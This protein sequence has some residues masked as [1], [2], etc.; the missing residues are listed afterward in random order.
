MGTTREP[1]FYESIEEMNK[2]GSELIDDL[3]KE[4]SRIRGKISDIKYVFG[5]GDNLDHLE[6]GITCIISAMHN[7]Q[8]RFQERENK[9]KLKEDVSKN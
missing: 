5:M 3:R 4:L 1:I 6:G 7:D 9:T 2:P 8:E